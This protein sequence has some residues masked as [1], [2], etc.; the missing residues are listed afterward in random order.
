MT[1]YGHPYASDPHHRPV[2]PFVTVSCPCALRWA[3]PRG[4]VKRGEDVGV[5]YVNVR[6][7]CALVLNDLR[8][9]NHMHFNLI[10]LFHVSTVLWEC[11][12]LLCTTPTGQRGQIV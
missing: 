2:Q 7:C 3:G 10:S 5:M 11:L 9:T 1:K 6:E 4:H 12:K 8:M